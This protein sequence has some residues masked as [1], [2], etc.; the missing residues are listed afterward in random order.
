MARISR[1]A[2]KVWSSLPY[3]LLGYVDKQDNKT[4]LWCE[5]L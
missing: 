3:L 2:D 5:W 1:I 4:A